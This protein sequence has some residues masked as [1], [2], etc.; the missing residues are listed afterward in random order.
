M[1]ESCPGSAA[2]FRVPLGF[3]PLLAIDSVVHHTDGVTQAPDV[4]TQHSH[5]W[6]YRGKMPLGLGGIKEAG[7]RRE[8]CRNEGKREE[9]GARDTC[10]CT[11]AT[12]TRSWE[13]SRV[14]FDIRLIPG[15]CFI[16]RFPRP[17]SDIVT[18]LPFRSVVWQE[19]MMVH[20][21]QMLQR[22]DGGLLCWLPAPR[23]EEHLFPNKS[24]DKN[25]IVELHHMSGN[26]EI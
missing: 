1:V 15:T 16:P 4:H 24:P 10:S 21:N 12:G 2:R 23:E 14:N 6:S 11:L 22:Q 3:R 9:W 7:W 19:G 17:S 20:V 13:K 26:V 18:S 5:F 8:E 25:D